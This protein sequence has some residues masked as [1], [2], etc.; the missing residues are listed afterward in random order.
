MNLA[1]RTGSNEHWAAPVRHAG[2]SAC[3]F[4][5]AAK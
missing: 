2:A 5:L 4:E 3:T 1:D